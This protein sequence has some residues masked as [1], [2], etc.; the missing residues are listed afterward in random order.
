MSRQEHTLFFPSFDGR[1]DVQGGV[2]E[3][4][5]P[6]GLHVETLSPVATADNYEEWL[7]TTGKVIVG[8]A[9][10][11]SVDLAAASNGGKI[12]LSLLVRHPD[13]VRRVAIINTKI[14]PYVFNNPATSKKFPNLAKTSSVLRGDLGRITT[15]MRS[16]VL[17]FRSYDDDVLDS[18]ED[19]VLEGSHIVTTPT[20]T[21][22]SGIE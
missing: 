22:A 10:E 6:H 2:A 4:W 3:L 9:Q 16:R 18:P 14:T 1:P 21:H 8:L 12:A 19:A 11:K 20:K 13:A 5:K 17:C 15:E 7:E